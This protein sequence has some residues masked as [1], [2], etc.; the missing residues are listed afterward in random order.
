MMLNPDG[1]IQ[2]ITPLGQ[3]AIEYIDRIGIPSLGESFVSPVEGGRN[4]KIR[5]VFS[6]DGKVQ[7]FLEK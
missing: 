2:R 4:A 1:S 6:P 7:T 5:L 3:A